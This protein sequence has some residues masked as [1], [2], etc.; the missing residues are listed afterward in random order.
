MNL[1][2]EALKDIKEDLL[3]RKS[4]ISDEINP[5]EEQLILPVMEYNYNNMNREIMERPILVPDIL[6]PKRKRIEPEQPE[7]AVND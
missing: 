2:L 1:R 4:K 6:V 3:M 7:S 5:D